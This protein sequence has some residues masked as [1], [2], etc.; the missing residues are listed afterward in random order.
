[1]FDSDWGGMEVVR[2]CVE[3]CCR[4]YEL[5]YGAYA[6][7]V[8]PGGPEMLAALRA[9][10]VRLGIVTGKSRRSWELTRERTALGPFDVLVFDDDVA[11]PKPDPEGIRIALDRLGAEPSEA[12]YIGDSGTDIEAAVA[13]GVRPAAA[14]WA[15][16]EADHE[17]FLRRVEQWAPAAFAAPADFARWV[18]E[19]AGRPAHS[20]QRLA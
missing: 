18:A 6:R 12:V 5:L 14:L 13:A 9:T 19:S 15:K 4:V 8:Y 20:V 10:G 3:D 1:G 16:K 2:A 7:G 17:A 11:E